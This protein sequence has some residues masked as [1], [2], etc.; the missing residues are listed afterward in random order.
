MRRALKVRHGSRVIGLILFAGASSLGHEIPNA[1]VDRSIQLT[2][3]PGQIA[4]D[5]EVSL[6]EL[7]LTQDLRA[8]LDGP[9]PEG[10]REAWFDR[11]GEVV[12]PLIARGVIVSVNGREISVG[13][14]RADWR[15]EGHPVFVFRLRAA[16]PPSGR[17]LLR[18]GNFVDAEGTSRLAIR[19]REGVVV[20]GDDGPGDVA[21]VPVRPVW[22]LTDAE[23]RRTRQLEVTYLR[24]GPAV[25]VAAPLARR[26]VAASSG[27][28]EGLVR[29]LGSSAGGSFWGLAVL[30]FGLGAA[31][32]VQPGHGKTLVLAATVG[33]GG[34]VGRGAALAGVLT[35]VH[36]GG[37]LLIAALLAATRTVRYE[38]LDRV[39]AHAAGFAIAA[40][41]CWRVGRHL[42]GWGEHEGPEPRLRDGRGIW[43]LGVAGG[44]VPCWDAVLLIVL[45]EAL[46][47]LALGV[48]LLGAFGLGMAAVLVAVGTLAGRVRGWAKRWGGR[49]DWPRR[50]GLAGG[51]VL[52]VIGVGMMARS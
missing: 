45:A 30:A 39:L 26:P 3:V 33:Q 46:G 48:A 34:G 25:V 13:F 22:E 38:S 21:E 49:A 12:G 23:E 4:L 51:V 36:L 44:L 5:Y 19:G 7:T 9:L 2:L 15:L 31:H 24:G 41:G 20:R 8:L 1:R 17:L 29:L 37:V 10:D 50:L 43:G 11:Y 14:E 6:G 32:A 35:V 28:G 40:V 47:R 18:D 27:R 52:A 16:I 42:A